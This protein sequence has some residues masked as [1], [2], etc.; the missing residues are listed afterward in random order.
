MK[1]TMII[2]L[3]SLGIIIT[4]TGCGGDLEEDIVGNYDSDDT[5]AIY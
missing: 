1:K 2:L 3:I 5:W 4:L